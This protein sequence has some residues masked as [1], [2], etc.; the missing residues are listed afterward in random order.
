MFLFISSVE[1]NWL[2]AI[3]RFGINL[4]FIGLMILLTARHIALRRFSFTFLMISLIVY[5]LCYTLKNFDL[6]LGMALGLFAIFGIIRYRTEP[7]QTEEM[8]YLFVTI[9]MAVI[10]ALS[11]EFLNLLELSLLNTIVLATILFGEFFLMKM[12]YNGKNHPLEENT[13]R[14]IALH[15]PYQKK[16]L[17]EKIKTEIKQQSINLDLD[18]KNYKIIKIDQALDIVVIHLYY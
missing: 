15:L 5:F 4:I 10:N 9:G 11:D 17:N 18:I 7:L 14:R 13:H 8:T 1:F 16:D 12:A 2:E 3:S 6:N